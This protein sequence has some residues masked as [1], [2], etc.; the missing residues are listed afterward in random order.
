VVQDQGGAAPAETSQ[1]GGKLLPLGSPSLSDVN[2]AVCDHVYITCDPDWEDDIMAQSSILDELVYWQSDELE[3]TIEHTEFLKDASKYL[4]FESD[5]GGFNNIRMAFEYFVMLAALTGR[6]LVLPPPVGW[7]LLDFGSTGF[8]GVYGRSSLLA[9]S[10]RLY[11]P[12][13][14]LPLSSSSLPPACRATTSILIWTICIAP[15]RW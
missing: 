13:P 12:L 15:C 8:Q 7:Y 5:A 10:R 1:G 6:T 3:K 2:I 9:L 11:S 14:S 4:T